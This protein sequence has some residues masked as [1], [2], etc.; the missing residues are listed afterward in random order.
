MGEHTHGRSEEPNGN[1]VL[2]RIAHALDAEPRGLL[3]PG[4]AAVAWPPVTDGLEWR[5][6]R[7]QRLGRG[8]FRQGEQ[9][10][11]AQALFH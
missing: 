3:E 5:S 2:D 7:P 4:R 9:H 6:D 10:E 8:P 1:V 11:N